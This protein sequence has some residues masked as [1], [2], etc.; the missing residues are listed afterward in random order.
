MPR[1][2]FTV[3]D[4]GST[5]RRTGRLL[6]LSMALH[7]MVGAAFVVAPLLAVGDPPPVPDRNPVLLMARPVLPRVEAVPAPPRRARVQQEAGRPPGPV[8]PPVSIAIPDRLVP[9]SE[10]D[11]GV[12]DWLPSGGSL[13]IGDLPSGGGG[14][15]AGGAMDGAGAAP[16]G[17]VPVGGRVERPR[18]LKDVA[19]E[20]PAIAKQARI[21]GDVVLDAV[22]GPD[23]F[24]RQVVVR[25]SD[26]SLLES[27]ALAAVRQ[28]VYEPTR[29]NDVPVAIVMSV[30]VSF[31]LR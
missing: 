13:G 24:V 4:G 6:P 1:D 14:E 25:E 29:L 26:S 23:G 5:T 3:P 7:A 27:A 20:Y 17:P 15:T 22:I 31:R 9:E 12:P 8:R 2:L 11:T 30:K 19:P 16:E 21:E 28:W 18:K 10:V